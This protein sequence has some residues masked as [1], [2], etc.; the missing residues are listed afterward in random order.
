M[1]YRRAAEL[2]AEEGRPTAAAEAAARGA[3]ALEELR[4]QVRAQLGWAV[5]LLGG[6]LLNA[7]PYLPTP[8]APFWAHAY[9]SCPACQPSPPSHPTQ[10]SSSLYRKAVEWLE[11]A[12]KDALA[13]DVFRCG[14]AAP[15]RRR[16]PAV[17]ASKDCS[18]QLWRLVP[19]LPICS[20]CPCRAVPTRSLPLF[21]S[22]MTSRQ[23]VAQL[24]RTEQWGEAVSMLLRFA[25]SCDGAGARNSQCKAYLGAVVVWLYAGKAKDAWV[26][27]QVGGGAGRLL[28]WW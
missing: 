20:S 9:T 2:F 17:F 27:Y 21:F 23:A 25:A 13:G 11:D 26:T 7:W 14:V 16:Q 8:S 6:G 4:P 1:H 24:V 12:G 28:E 22:L 10:A 5:V 3:R 15:G 18:L 19:S